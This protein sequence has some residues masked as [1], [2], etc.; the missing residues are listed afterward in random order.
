M[1]IEATESSSYTPIYNV[2][3]VARLCG[4]P[5]VTLRAWERRYGLPSPARGDQGYRLYSERDVLTLRW[6]KKKIDSGLSI[7]RAVQLFAEIRASGRD[8]AAMPPTPLSASQPISLDDLQS[9]FVAA[10]RVVDEPTATMSLQTALAVAPLDDVLHGMIRHAMITLGDEW[11]QGSLPIA[12]EHFASQFCLQWLRNLTAAV[13]APTRAGVIVAGGA[14]GEQHELGLLMIV[15]ML[16]RRGWDVKYLGPNLMVARLAEALAHL[17]PRLLLFTASRVDSAA[18]LAA[19][20]EALAAF[21]PRPM[22]VVGGTGFAALGDPDMPGTFIDGTP[23]D[24]VL[25]IERMMT[26]DE[27]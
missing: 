10:L 20:P 12:V 11:H 6:L 18:A 7:S 19:L 2:K 9:T 27:R 1:D 15:L 22:V 21:N 17:K 23:A 4:I 5:A 8:P 26:K 24:M 25:S 16:R 14:P 13:G 3:A